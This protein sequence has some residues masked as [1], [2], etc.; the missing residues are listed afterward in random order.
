MLSTNVAKF[1]VSRSLKEYFGD[2][3]LIKLKKQRNTSSL[4]YDVIKPQD[5]RQ[6]AS[7]NTV[8]H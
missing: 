1:T 7:I 8:V 3:E 4:H 5:G 2:V 6:P